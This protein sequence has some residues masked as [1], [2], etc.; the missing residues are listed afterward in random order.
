MLK[1]HLPIT[2]LV[3]LSFL[4]LNG[5]KEVSDTAFIKL[6]STSNQGEEINLRTYNLLTF[7]TDPIVSAN[8]DTLNNTISVPLEKPL[9]CVLNIGEKSAPLYLEKGFNLS[10]GNILL[11][12]NKFMLTGTGAGINKYLIDF[13]EIEDKAFEIE[14]YIYTLT[15]E[16]FKLRMDSLQQSLDGIN[17][18]SL[19]DNGLALVKKIKEAKLINYKLNHLFKLYNLWTERSGVPEEDIPSWGQLEQNIELFDLKLIDYGMSLHFFLDALVYSQLWEPEYAGNDSLTQHFYKMTND[20][21]RS[22]KI[23]N[24]L[25]EI[26][27]AKNIAWSFMQ[28]GLNPSTKFIYNGFKTSF[29]NSEH[30][31]S[32]KNIYIGLTILRAGEIAPDIVGI[33]PDGKELS[34]SEL[35]GKMLFVDIWA[36]WCG[37]CIEAF[38]AAEKLRK[39]YD[40]DK[41]N[42]IYLSVDEDIEKWEGFLKKNNDLKGVHLIEK[43][44]RSVFE[45]YQLM[46]IPRYLIIDKEGKTVDADAPSPTSGEMENI[47][48]GLL[49]E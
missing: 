21:I 5:C 25:K 12:Q 23:G 37:P 13:D 43:E 35:K 45:N 26:L 49:G 27:L 16:A 20:S 34:L 46:G 29:P 36:T 32:L 28:T 31:P 42:F 9:F 48:D 11:S 15:K 14:P 24:K 8:F 18:S 40:E 1:K 41:I 10:V 2:T 38:P 33:T 17:T 4:I 6:T 3:L 7:D 22:I 19:S 39:K 30:L 47:L 44:K